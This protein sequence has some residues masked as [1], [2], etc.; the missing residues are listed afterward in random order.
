MLQITNFI[1]KTAAECRSLLKTLGEN[2]DGLSLADRYGGRESLTA[3]DVK[4]LVSLIENQIGERAP[5]NA[6]EE[7][8]DESPAEQEEEK[9]K[10]VK[11]NNPKAAEK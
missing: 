3:D 1:P 7:K 8:N 11:K 5:A 2:P 6:P 10:P 9:P 4:T